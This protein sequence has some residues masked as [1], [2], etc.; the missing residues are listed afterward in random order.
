MTFDNDTEGSLDI[1]S[2]AEIAADEKIERLMRD[3]SSIEP[4][5]PVI[6]SR[7][8][9][10]WCKG[11]LEKITVGDDGLD[12]D[13]LIRKWGGHSLT[14][15]I[16]GSNGHFRGTHAVELYSWPPRRNGK[17]LKDPNRFD[18]EEDEDNPGSSRPTAAVPPA[19][20]PADD[21]FMQ[22][23]E[24]MN[25]Q[26]QSEVDTLR[27]LL[28]AQQQA[29][30]PPAAVSPAGTVGDMVKMFRAFGELREMVAEGTAP[31]GD[32]IEQLPGQVMDLVKM[33]IDAKTREPRARV[34]PSV[35]PPA[36]PSP[37]RA[38]E[39][40][41]AVTMSPA[42]PE[43]KVTPIRSDDL[44]SQLSGLDP[45]QAAE[46]LV[47]AFSRMPPEKQDLAWGAFMQRFNDTMGGEYE[48]VEEAENEPQG[49]ETK[50][51]G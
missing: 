43:R 34:V 21:R 39:I 38:H 42:L 23:L 48:M 33:F 1:R 15:K 32:T 46:T 11:Q 44:V 29:A 8:Q 13:Y 25:R 40:S 31:A 17:I 47:T 30:P 5:V 10:S 49:A 3:L 41:N 37:N 27:S 6:I 7:T 4:G 18:D 16:M 9:P 26:R 12:L 2:A 51:S 45:D 14:V 20:S 36:A 28:L 19:S 50:T 22:L 24:L 35:R